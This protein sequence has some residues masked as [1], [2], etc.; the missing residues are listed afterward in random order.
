MGSIDVNRKG[1][2]AKW[3]EL[4]RNGGRGKVGQGENG[5]SILRKDGLNSWPYILYHEDDEK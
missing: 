3:R 1:R 2:Y 5:W 4:S